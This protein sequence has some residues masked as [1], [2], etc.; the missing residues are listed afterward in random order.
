MLGI[1]LIE[2]EGDDALRSRHLDHGIG[3][4]DDCHKFQ[5]ERS[6]KDTVV[7]DVEAA[8]LKCQYL[9]RLVFP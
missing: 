1:T 4:V 2:L 5:E 8:H 9:P 3:S 7:L 6:P